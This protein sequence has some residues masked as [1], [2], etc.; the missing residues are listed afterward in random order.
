[1]NKQVYPIVNALLF[2]SDEPVEFERL[3]ELLQVEFPDLLPSDL[4]EVLAQIDINLA[5]SGVVLSHTDAGFQIQIAEDYL[6][7]VYKLFEQ[8]PPRL[9]RALLETLSIITHKQPITRP[10][11]EEIRG[12]AV[13]T[14]IMGQLREFGWVRTAGKKE[15]PGRPTL[16]ATTD[17]LVADL[18]LKSKDELIAK[19][20]QIIEEF[21]ATQENPEPLENLNIPL[22]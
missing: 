22:Q 5:N 12:V 3:L 11:I 2:A 4:E 19:L 15:T 14:Y 16:W 6:P 13:S 8:S 18:S 17:K 20:D 7:W 10:E 9:S 21:M 1:M